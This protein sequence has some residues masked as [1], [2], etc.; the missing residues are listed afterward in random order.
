MNDLTADKFLDMYHQ[1]VLSLQ[2]YCLEEQEQEELPLI[3]DFA[4][5]VYMRR[6][7]MRKGIFV[8]GKTHKTKHLN[9]VMSGSANVMVNGIVKFLSA[10][11]VFISEAGDKKLLYIH[12]DMIWGTIHPTDETDLD[13]LEKHCICTPE[14]EKMLLL[15][16]DQL[17]GLL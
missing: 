10:P 13:K 1:H 8:M 17:G 5:G 4:P 3:H 16:Q 6:V 9:L 7:L 15:N 11:D 2:E 14:E 12:E